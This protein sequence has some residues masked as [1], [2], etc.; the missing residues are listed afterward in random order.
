MDTIY[1]AIIAPLEFIGFLL[2]LVCFWTFHNIK[3]RQ[4]GIKFYKYMKIYSLAAAV[5]TS[6]ILGFAFMSFSPRY[7]IDFIHPI[8]KFF[9]C[10]IIAYPMITL[11]FFLNLLDILISIDRMSIFT[12]KLKRFESINPFNLS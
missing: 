7:F 2:N 9:R 6:L 12:A 5:V 10:R 3:I 1:I 8:V 11:F 4:K